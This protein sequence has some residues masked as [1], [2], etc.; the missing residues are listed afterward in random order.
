MPR[1]IEAYHQSTIHTTGLKDIVVQVHERAL[2]HLKEAQQ[3]IEEGKLNELREHITYVQ[4]V[5]T[6]LR[7][8][9]DPEFAISNELALIYQGYLATLAQIF[10]QPDVEE[11]ATIQK[12]FENWLAFWKSAPI[13]PTVR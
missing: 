12:A 5:V 13:Q 4:D 3:N 11:I 2:L 10:I 9:I 8:S 7:G 6:F 1:G